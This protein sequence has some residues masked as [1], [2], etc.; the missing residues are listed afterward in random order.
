M[1]VEF[2]ASDMLYV[3]VED[4]DGDAEVIAASRLS[5]DDTRSRSSLSAFQS[6]LATTL[7]SYAVDLIAIKSKPEKGRMMAGAAALKMEALLLASAKSDVRFVSGAR[8]K[9]VESIDN[10]LHKYLQT[11]LLTA[12]AAR[13]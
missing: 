1:G 12:L 6:V 7:N 5:L 11:A 10:T 9:Q 13:G 2:D 3:V 4:H 8:V